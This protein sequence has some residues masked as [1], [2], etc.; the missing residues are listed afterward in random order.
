[1]FCV[2]NE[3]GLLDANGPAGLGRLGVLQLL[4]DL[5]LL[6]EEGANDTFPDALVAQDSSVGTT[7][8]LLA[9]GQ[10]ASLGRTGGSD[11][12]ELLLALAALGHITTL[13]HV[14]VDQAATG[15]ANTA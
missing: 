15:S 11:S 8:G 4:D 3:Y 14:L 5:L 9:L 6:D 2:G 7:N 1:M 13:L 10:T 12:V